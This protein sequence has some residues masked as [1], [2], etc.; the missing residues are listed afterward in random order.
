VGK[1]LTIKIAD[2]AAYRTLFSRDYYY[3]DGRGS[4]PIRWMAPESLLWV[5]SRLKK[6]HL[7]SISQ[8][9]DTWPFWV[10]MLSID[11]PEMSRKS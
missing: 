7:I 9:K 4:L 5:S 11:W 8:M 6:I 3:I 10:E 1:S 2:F